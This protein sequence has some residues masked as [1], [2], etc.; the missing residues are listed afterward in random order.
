MT[1]DTDKSP[2]P[3]FPVQDTMIH[4]RVLQK[5]MP[6]PSSLLCRRSAAVLVSRDLAC[7]SW[8][9]SPAHYLSSRYDRARVLQVDAHPS[10]SVMS[11]MRSGKEDPGRWI[12]AREKRCNKCPAWCYQSSLAQNSHREFCYGGIN[13][14]KME[15]RSE[16]A[17]VLYRCCLLESR[18]G[19][20][21]RHAGT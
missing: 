18:Y 11:L 6:S 17:A 9:L 5:Q 12:D 7:G 1:D 20:S 21:F 16:S 2:A 3:C 10:R 19:F 15:Q 13:E 4:D 14:S 8:G